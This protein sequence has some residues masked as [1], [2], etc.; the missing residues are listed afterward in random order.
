MSPRQEMGFFA[1]FFWRKAR[2][3]ADPQEPRYF[4]NG[5]Q[6]FQHMFPDREGQRTAA[7]FL[8][9]GAERVANQFSGPVKARP[10][11]YSGF[12]S[13]ARERIALEANHRVGPGFD[14]AMERMGRSGMRTFTGRA[15]A[16][17]GGALNM[18]EATAKERAV[19]A[20]RM[21][22]R[23]MKWGARSVGSLLSRPVAAAASITGRPQTQS[24]AMAGLRGAGRTALKLGTIPLTLA[25]AG[26][27]LAL[28]LGGLALRGGEA[29][30]G[31]RLLAQ[32][33]PM[34][35]QVS[36]GI[37]WAGGV[38]AVGYAAGSGIQAEERGR[39][40]NWQVTTGAGGLPE[41]ERTDFM[42]ATGSLAMAG[43]MNGG[44]GFPAMN[45]RNAAPALAD[46]AVMLATR[47][48][49]R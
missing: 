40:T 37:Q 14:A 34:G 22:G 4:E 9:Q 47:M 35:M 43:Y 33:G 26:G 36:P 3:F 49:M 11:E 2:R 7:S 42:G 30:G 12:G 5:A 25:A 28:G 44:S 24:L 20:L 18:G 8:T 46:D 41:M 39:R 32:G 13:Y 19:H 38:G 27:A 31:G 23:A 21:Q 45:F 17:A 15:G 48:L 10:D 29:L 6:A 1:D 16:F